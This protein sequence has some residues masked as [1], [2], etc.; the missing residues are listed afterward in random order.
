MD[1]VAIILDDAGL[2]FVYKQLTFPQILCKQVK[3]PG[4]YMTIGAL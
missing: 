2:W 3:S 4:K 1:L